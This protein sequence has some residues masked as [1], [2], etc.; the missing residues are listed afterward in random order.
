MTTVNK[1]LITKDKFSILKQQ[2]AFVYDSQLE[3]IKAQNLSFMT[4]DSIH[5]D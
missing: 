2:A 4:R 5:I 1:R 3:K